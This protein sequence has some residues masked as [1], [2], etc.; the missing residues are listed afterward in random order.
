MIH[1][2]RRAVRYKRMENGTNVPVTLHKPFHIKT[3]LSPIT[4]YPPKA[5]ITTQKRRQKNIKI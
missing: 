3:I 2:D 5:G 1:L 4:V